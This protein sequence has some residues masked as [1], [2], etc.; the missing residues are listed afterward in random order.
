M[1]QTTEGRRLR[2][3][4]WGVRGSVPT[5][6]RENLGIG[7]NTACVELETADEAIV[8]FDAGSGIRN[9][10]LDLVQR[11]NG[12][13]LD[14]HLFFT[15]FHLDHIIGLPFFLPLLNKRNSVT[16]YSS[17]YS[18]PS[19]SSLEGLMAFPYFPLTFDSVPAALNIAKVTSGEVRLGRIGV[20]AFP[21]CHPQGACGF[22]IQVSGATVI[23]IPDREPGDEQLDR[24][25][26][27]FS[28]GAELL[29]HDSNY[30]PAEYE[31]YRGWGHSPWTEAVQLARDAQVNRLMLFHHDPRHTD[32]MVERI[33]GKARLRFPNTQA[34]TEGA[35]LEI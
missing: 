11:A 9:L 6:C 20:Q 8:I 1:T 26:R 28:R 30:T 32:E 27:E 19:G 17:P 21:V 2:I 14:I 18:A 35:S 34:A 4:F 15:H 5:P 31:N 7:G 24:A 3:K 25:A 33:A 23:H 29:I 16:I 12:Q 13:P 10:G 22:R